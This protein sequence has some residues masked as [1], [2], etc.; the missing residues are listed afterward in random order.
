MCDIGLECICVTFIDD[1]S[2][3]TWVSIPKTKDKVAL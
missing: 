2:N 3:K 1:L